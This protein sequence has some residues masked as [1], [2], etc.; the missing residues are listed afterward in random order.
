MGGATGWGSHL[1][2]ALSCKNPNNASPPLQ[3]RTQAQGEGV[4]KRGIKE[5][6]TGTIWGGMTGNAGR[7]HVYRWGWSLP[8]GC[9]CW[10]KSPLERLKRFLQTSLAA[11]SLRMTSSPP[12]TKWMRLVCEGISVSQP[13][14]G[15]AAVPTQRMTQWQVTQHLNDLPP[16][17]ARSSLALYHHH[18]DIR[19]TH[20]IIRPW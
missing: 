13:S 12:S 9:V 7:N 19:E 6:K 14:R 18:D 8:Y 16:A 2:N 11:S 20:V 15:W 4:E 5:E 3:E 1:R 17:E 10:V